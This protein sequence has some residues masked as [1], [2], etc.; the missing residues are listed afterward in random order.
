MK[1]KKDIKKIALNCISIE[2]DEAKKLINKID[3]NFVD[4]INV[5]YQNKG[6]IIITAIG[7]SANISNK[8]VATLNSTGSPAI[9]VHAAEA[10]HGDLG[11]IKNED[12]I[13]C[14]SNSGNTDEIKLLVSQIRGLQN[15]LIAITG[16]RSSFLA[17][18]A[19]YVLDVGVEKEACLNNLAPTSSTTNQLVM[20]DAIA[21]SLLYCNGFTKRDFA[22]NHPG[23][24]LGKRISISLE[25]LISKSSFVSVNYNDNLQKVIF[26]ISN[27]C[28]GATAVV[29]NKNLIGIITDGDLRRMLQKTSNITKIIAKDIMS[30]NPKTLDKNVL[31]YEA[32]LYM[33]KNK[34]NQIIVTSNN[35]YMGIVHI[36]EILKQELV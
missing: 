25:D 17:K 7:K 18:Y 13:I 22:K 9:F 20:G 33:Q 1:S 24:T 15:K 30:A 14:I 5:L 11:V 36:N 8:I 2:V 27:K 19:D 23:G 3:D 28:L 6:R 29:K 12:I 35:E 4:I 16:N 21:V 10:V 32:L 34:I 31:A 26:E